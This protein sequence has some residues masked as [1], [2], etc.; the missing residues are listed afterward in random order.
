MR[1]ATSSVSA[2]LLIAI[3]SAPLAVAQQT[4]VPALGDIMAAIQWRHI[5]LWFAGKREN[6]ELATYELEHIR[7]SLE[8]AAT[9]CHGIPADYVG[10]TVEPIKAINAAIEAKDGARFA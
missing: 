6:W 2:A 4:Y 9:F 3:V 8:E 10:A 1:N 7:T 5:K